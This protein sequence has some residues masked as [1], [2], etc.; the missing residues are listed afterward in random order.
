MSDSAT[1]EQTNGL[2]IAVIGMTGRF[3]GAKTIDEF[4]QNLRNG[5]ES[6]RFFS[7]AE[8][9]ES[10][11]DAATLADPHY[12]KAAPTL[13]DVDL[14]DA[15]FFGYNPKE[16]EAM[17][18]QQRIF[19]ECAWEALER[20]GY[21]ADTYPGA[22]GVY[23]GVSMSSYM[24]NL[25]SNRHFMQAADK[26][27]FLIALGNDKDFLATR[28]SY[29]LNLSGPSFVVQTACSTSLVA[30]HL[31]CQGLLGGECD[32]ALAGGV[33]VRV[34]QKSGYFHVEGGIL[35]PDGHCRAFDARAQGTLFGS[36]VGIVVLK[37]LEDALADGDS[38][39]AV[40]KGTAINNDGALKV[41]YT[42]PSVDGQARVIRAAQA[43]AEIHPESIS[44]IEAHGTGTALGD[45][46]EIAALTQVFRE[47]TQQQGFCA[48]GSVKSNIGHLD[49]AAG[50]AGLIKTILALQHAQIPP[51]LH[52]EQPNPQIDFAR[53]PFYVNTRLSAWPSNG[54]PRRAGV[55]S[56]GIG[57]TNA[58]VVLEEAPVAEPP[59]PARPWHLLTLS[60][61]TGSALEAATANLVAHFRE[62]TD[63][64]L[65]DATYTLQVGRKPFEHRRMLVCHD[66]ADAVTALETGDPTRVLT[67]VQEPLERGV[68]FVFPG[69]GTQYAG[70]AAGLYRH[71]PAFRAQVDH[72]CEALIP[73]LGLDLRPILYPDAAHAE[74]ATRQLDQTAITQPALFVIEYAL[75][76]L[77]MAWGVRPQALIGHSI[78][79]YVAACLAG[80]FSLEDALALVVAR[81]RLMQSLPAGSMLSVA[82]AEEELR[83]LL[84][85]DL[86]LA[87]INAPKLSVVSG[88]TSAIE[89]LERRL[90]ERGVDCRRLHTSHAFH[91]RM[92]DPI[93]SPFAAQVER[94]RLSPPRIP[95]VSN[96]SGTWMTPEEATDPQYWVT[97]LRQPVRFA[98]GLGELLADPTRAI[99]EVGPGR[100]LSTLARQHPAVSAGR[101]I[102]TS[103][104]HPQ[105]QT[106]DVAFLLTTLGRLWLA[107]VAIDWRGV[108]AHARRR[109]IPLPT[110]PF[111][112][113]RYWVERQS[114]EDV[115][116]GVPAAA[117]QVPD[118]PEQAGRP[119]ETT[120]AAAPTPPPAT[121]GAALHQRPELPNAYVAPRNELERTIAEVWQDMLGISPVGVYDNFFELGGHSLLATQIAAR[122]RDMLPIDLPVRRVFDAQTVA[123][124]AVAV[125]Q[126]LAEQTGE[127]DVAQI[128][129][130]IEQL[131]Q[132]DEQAKVGLHE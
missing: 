129:T 81:G 19:L 8:L 86:D 89:R 49:T 72:C 110:Y 62:H 33:S 130:E 54:R 109:R 43:V 34:P 126:A 31:A 59:G 79:E 108:Y 117:G 85:A 113:R 116:G 114:H 55:S 32:M 107:D 2:E 64:N 111:E 131:S 98:D 27:Q 77:W 102:L 78:G 9:R 93:L 82:L 74:T 24:L 5:V 115:P 29:K 104:R 76:R 66:L 26:S 3:P 123:D 42:A 97:H 60:A 50:I 69:Q 101:V 39:L 73:H 103:L 14:F 36:G 100:T 57:G 56:F 21:A 119:V 87:A 122:L 96:R 16:A 45:P 37:R 35:S 1:F 6:I 65:A 58:H 75:A 41:G 70:M 67:R 91:S 44:Y 105:D 48:I 71:E 38:I 95:V 40:V 10:G 90:A 28:V 11:I 7:D 99:L 13:E 118:C 12:V 46:I 83:P 120:A 30:L 17:D 112:R 47:K 88:P 80:V 51:S 125:V 68:A 23:A 25:F 127:A 4:W 61:K 132:D 53:S 20:A 94:V 63:L 18:P 92:M 121:D 15:V 128:L 124:L 84:E 106:P 52:F 22:I